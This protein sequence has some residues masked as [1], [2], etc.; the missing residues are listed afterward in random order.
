MYCSLVFLAAVLSTAYCAVYNIEMTRT[1]SQ[2]S[3][4]IRDGTWPAYLKYKELMRMSNKATSSQPMND[5]V[6]VVYIGNITLG[7]PQQQF[8]VVL[9]TGSSNLWVADKTCG[10]VKRAKASNGEDISKAACPK[11]TTFD[12]SKSTTYVADGRK[13]SIQY[14]TGSTKGFLGQDTACFGGTGT[15]QLCVPKVI[16]GQ[17]TTIH[18]IYG[19][20]ANDGMLGLAFTSIAADHITPPLIQAINMGLLDQPIFTVWLTHRGPVNNVRGGMI[21]YGALDTT[22]CGNV[23]A[24]QPLSSA[25]WWQFRMNGVSCGSY[26]SSQGWEVMSD[27]GTSY[28]GAPASVVQQLARQV[29]ATY[30]S[31]YQTYSIDCNSPKP[32]IVFTI[33]TNSYNLKP[34]NYV[35]N[36]GLGF[37]EFSFFTL[38]G[39][40]FFPAWILGDPF[41][42]QVCN[43]YDIGQQRIGFAAPLH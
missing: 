18:P 13:W 2:R 24:Y 12:S 21:T 8:T 23:I 9:D 14:E 22:N 36:E 42:R 40:G 38:N 19:N 20:N 15:S 17:A 1:P 7:N 39:A 34:E 30:V 41:I 33:G 29:G 32:D 4:M 35:V 10:S 16:F 28:I 43:V 6:D 11:K 5:Y 37:C 26:T 31:N 3:K 25:T 27:T